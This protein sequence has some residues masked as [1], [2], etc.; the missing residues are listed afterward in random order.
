[1]TDHECSACGGT[2]RIVLPVAYGD[3]QVGDRV[4]NRD[5]YSG[6]R[7]HW[8]EV[9]SIRCDGP[10][11]G[12]IVHDGYT[13]W[14]FSREGVG[15]SRFCP[16]CVG[17]GRI[18]D[19][20]PVSDALAD[21]ETLIRFAADD[22]G[23]NIGDAAMHARSALAWGLATYVPGRTQGAKTRKRTERVRTYSVLAARAAFR[24]VPGLREE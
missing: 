18:S 21:A 8:T 13:Q 22:P 17:A 10:Q 23:N 6:P 12:L 9:M 1:M 2:G 16:V 14:G 19:K 20:M 15:V 7:G 24:A 5:G 4:W 11:H 3:V